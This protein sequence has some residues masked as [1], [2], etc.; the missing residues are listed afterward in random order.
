MFGANDKLPVSRRKQCR[1]YISLC[2]GK[3]SYLVP[4]NQPFYS[5]HASRPGA[6]VVLVAVLI[7]VLLGFTVLAVDVGYMYDTRAELQNAADSAAMAAAAFLSSGTPVDA[8]DAVRAEACKYA[9]ANVAATK[10]CVIDSEA[11]VVLGRANLNYATGQYDFTESG[12]P[13]DAVKVIVRR[14]SQRSSGPVTLFFAG[15]FGKN[16]TEIS[17]SAVAALVPRDIAMTVDLSGSMNDDSE[18]GYYKDGKINLTNVWRDLAVGDDGPT[19]GNM[20]VWGTEE[21]DPETYRPQDDPGLTYMPYRTNWSTLDVNCDGIDDFSQLPSDYTTN[22]KNALKNGSYDSYRSRDYYA[23]RVAVMLRLADWNDSD[24][25][26]KIDS[27]EVSYR[28]YPYSGGSWRDWI[29]NYVY[30]TSTVMYSENSAFRYRFG[31]KTFI[32]YLL[33]NRESHAETPILAQAPCQPLE[34]VKDGVRICLQIMDDLDSNDQMSLEIY[35]TAPNHEYDLTENLDEVGTAL[36]NMQAGHYDSYTCIGGGL[37]IALDELESGRARGYA[38]KI[39][40]L[41]TDGRANIDK[42]GNYNESGARDYAIEQ[43]E[44]AAGLGVRI[45]TISVG[46]G[47]DRALM[48]EIASITHAEEFFASSND[49]DEYT[50]QLMDIFGELGGK[51]PVVLIK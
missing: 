28:S 10:N 35:A 16:T 18:L 1:Q 34:A 30:S 20:V 44:R 32:N 5:P 22:E 17:A 3:Q 51:R 29:K 41:M 31:L 45:Y 50:A 25:D 40:M 4:A 21:I 49:P 26:R 37:K 15:I 6:I 7:V 48:Q 2:T 13:W 47:A 38:K 9:L 19:W 46:V 11:D 33:E 14:D 23:D 8:E 36:D 39:V 24:G 43:A 27:N 12:Y 42:Y